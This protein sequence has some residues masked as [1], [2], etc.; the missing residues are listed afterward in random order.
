MPL[1]AH[2]SGGL[3]RLSLRHGFAGRDVRAS[4]AFILAIGVGGGTV[5]TL[6]PLQLE[7]SGLSASAVGALFSAAAVV[8]VWL[9]PAAGRIADRRGVRLATAVWTAVSVGLLLG[10]ALTGQVWVTSLLLVG[11]LPQ[12][13][14]GGTLSYL[15]G[16]RSAAL[17][18]RLG[19]SFGMA[20]AAWSV[21]AS[22]G[23]IASGYV[24]QA[25]S[26]SVAYIFAAAVTGILLSPALTRR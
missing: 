15:L 18:G 10:L 2:A 16:A 25:T 1:D 7:A 6:A 8:A 11:F 13:R 19:A 12:I 4:V 20:I 5:Q 24:A 21:G 9:A 23:P 17:G 14:S 26:R 22:L 3:R